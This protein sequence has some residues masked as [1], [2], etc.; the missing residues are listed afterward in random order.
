VNQFGNQTGMAHRC[1]NP[2]EQVHVSDE[3]SADSG[4][5]RQPTPRSL[6]SASFSTMPNPSKSKK[7]AKPDATF[8][9]GT[10]IR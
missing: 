3:D 6:V 10:Q 8:E 9:V 5:S 1:L 4:I 7:A 2:S